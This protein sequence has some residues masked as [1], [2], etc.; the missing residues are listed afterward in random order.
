MADA[1]DIVLAGSR[2]QHSNP[3]DSLHSRTAFVL[4]VDSAIVTFGFYSLF[5]SL[6]LLPGAFLSLIH[7]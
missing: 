5:G 4:I 3:I 7:I 2:P 1:D 6:A